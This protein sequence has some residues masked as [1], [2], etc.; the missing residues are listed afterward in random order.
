MNC[1][2]RVFGDRGFD[3]GCTKPATVERDGKWYCKI[4]DPEYI[5]QKDNVRQ[6]KWDKESQE[7]NLRWNWEAVRNSATN[8]LTLEELQHVTPEKIRAWLS[9]EAKP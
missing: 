7:R 4:H 2:K 8:G 5:K 9:I 6:V 1:S 3:Y